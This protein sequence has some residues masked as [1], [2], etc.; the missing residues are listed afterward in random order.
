MRTDW[1]QMMRIN[2]ARTPN[3][4]ISR[5]MKEP[6]AHLEFC[7]QVYRYQ[8]TRSRCF[9]HGHPAS[10]GSWHEPNM[11]RLPRA[12]GSILSKADQCQYGPLVGDKH[13]KAP[14]KKH[15]SSLAN[16]PCIASRPRKKC[17]GSHAHPEGRHAGP[18]NGA[19][20]KAEV[21]PPGLCD[22]ICA[23]MEEQ[24]ECD[25]EGRFLPLGLAAGDALAKEPQR[26]LLNPIGSVQAKPWNF[27]RGGSGA[28]MPAACVGDQEDVMG[29]W[30]TRL[31]KNQSPLKLRK[32]GK[33]QLNIYTRATFTLKPLEEKLQI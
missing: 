14:A 7:I 15:T 11:R 24:M 26:E 21:Y 30:V 16:S 10:A 8:G 13:G 22:A 29:A 23:G 17:E 12:Q 6:R 5:R 18:F 1:P 3:E 2:W 33:G 27:D 31:A 9:L 4:E 32:L 25:R 20:K 28:D 19:A